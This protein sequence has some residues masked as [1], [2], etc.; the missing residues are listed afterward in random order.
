MQIVLGNPHIFKLHKRLQKVGPTL[1]ALHDINE[2]LKSL[3]LSIRPFLQSAQ[4]TGSMP[5][6]NQ[7]KIPAV[8]PGGPKLH[9]PPNPKND[10]FTNKDLRLGPARLTH[11]KNRLP[12]LKILAVPRTRLRLIS[13]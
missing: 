7:L 9:L 12:A 2:S 8:H 1:R 5:H 13:E 6:K 3:S 4:I 10:W 11:P